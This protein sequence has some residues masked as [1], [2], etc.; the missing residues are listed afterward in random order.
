MNR[1]T[2][3][4]QYVELKIAGRTE[5]AYGKIIDS[6]QDIVVLFNGIQY[7]FIPLQHILQIRIV[8]SDTDI[9]EFLTATDIPLEFERSNEAISYRKVLMNAKGMFSE[10][11]VTGN[12]TI[13]GY[14]TSVM[15]DFFV[16][17]S[18]VYH[19]VIIS[20]YHLKYLIPYSPNMT[21]YTLTQEK[22][23]LKPSPVKL[24]RTFDQQLLKM[25]GEF[26]VFDLGESPNKVGV[27]KKVEQNMAELTNADGSPV[28]LSLN[29]IK[30]V[31][32]P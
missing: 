30:T 5:P 2:L 25:V 23:P 26:A 13:H 17:Y 28:L 11:Y 8:T 9:G 24:S 21:P 19:T 20:I 10:L 22:F 32:L 27:L 4:D 16:F 1:K 3:I 12:H 14:I 29:H 7:L 18:P 6:G 31:H 15:N